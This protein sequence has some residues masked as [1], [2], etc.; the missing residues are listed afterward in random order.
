MEQKRW[1]ENKSC[2]PLPP[3]IKFDQMVRWFSPFVSLPCFGFFVVIM[4]QG[5]DETQMRWMLATFGITC[6]QC[7][8]VFVCA[9]ACVRH[10]PVGNLWNELSCWL[11]VC[12]CVCV[13]WMWEYIDFNIALCAKLQGHRVHQQT[14]S[15]ANYINYIK[16]LLSNSETKV[17]ITMYWTLTSQIIKFLFKYCSIVITDVVPGRSAHRGESVTLWRRRVK[18]SLFN[19]QTIFYL[20][21]INYVSPKAINSCG[22]QCCWRYP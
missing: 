6:R 7:V 11:L 16:L 9:A 15:N 13:C 18:R 10:M 20:Y 19:I 14:G 17:I 2:P 21:W 4:I 12:V 3:L 5:I 1:L 8:C 22:Q